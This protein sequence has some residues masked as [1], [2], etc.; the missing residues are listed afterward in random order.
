MKLFTLLVHIA[1][2]RALS[3]CTAYMNWRFVHNWDSGLWIFRTD[4]SYLEALMNS[5]RTYSV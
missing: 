4:L 3:G 5:F 1:L 2:W